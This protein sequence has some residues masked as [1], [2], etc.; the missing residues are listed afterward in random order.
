M[1]DAIF[2]DVPAFRANFVAGAAPAGMEEKV[3]DFAGG[4]SDVLQRWSTGQGDSRI[5][6]DAAP[7]KYNQ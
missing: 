5:T 7:P 1:Q 6:P 2:V 4:F 3:F